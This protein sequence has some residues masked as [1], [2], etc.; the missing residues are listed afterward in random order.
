ME[1]LKGVSLGE[2]L[3]LLTKSRLGWKSKPRAKALAYHEHSQI[4]A[5]KSF[6]TSGPVANV[7]KLFTV[8]SYTFS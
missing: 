8:V 4:T 1:R 2:A 3:G 5:V 7:I 6:I